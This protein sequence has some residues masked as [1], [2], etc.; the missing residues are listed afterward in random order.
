MDK[1]VLIS[2]ASIAGLTLAYWLNNYG[3]K[4]TVV[5]ITK[6]LRRGGSPIDVRGEALAVA[7]KMGILKKIKTKEFLHTDEIVNLNNETIVNFSINA[8]EE[9]LGDIEI[10]RD[11]LVDILFEN[12]PVN[13]VQFLFENRIEKLLQDEDS[14]EITF[15]TG[16]TRSF[17]FVFGA[18]GAHSTVRKMAFGSEENYSKFFGEYFAIV[19]AP[20]ITPNK[21]NSASMYNEPGKMASI[22]PFK[23][24][25]NAFLVFRSEKLN[26][27]YKDQEQHK[28]IL[29]DN[30]KNSSWRIPE[31]LQ[32]VSE[33][34]NLYFDEVCQIQMDSWAQG[35]V[36]LLGDAGY[37]PS[38]H[39]GMGTSLAMQGAMILAD[40]LHQTDDFKTAF[41]N[42][43]EIY[44]PF[45]ETTQAKIKEGMDFLVPE[46]EEGIKASI[47]RFK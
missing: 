8:Q 43:S 41:N 42:Y 20:N 39:T 10:H 17:D 38:F 12:I 30:F 23:N 37:A 11:D 35:R 29:I 1:N 31:I 24:G 47:E 26:W 32:A 9:Y 27:D 45:V 18:D 36:A 13:E 44:R 16:E 15:K 5:E 2:G 34:D 3:Y 21:P 4:V 19:E 6:G 25:V 22:V 28:Q 40:Q 7:E 46:T 14:I 33:T